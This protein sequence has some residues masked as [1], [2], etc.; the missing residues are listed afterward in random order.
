MPPCE[1]DSQS[2]HSHDIAGFRHAIFEG[3]AGLLVTMGRGAVAAFCA[4]PVWLRALCWG[5]AAPPSAIR[6][7]PGS[8][9]LN[10][11]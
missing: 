5:R 3:G 1:V 10:G 11:V 8:S 7:R 2:G 4:V 6:Q 9:R